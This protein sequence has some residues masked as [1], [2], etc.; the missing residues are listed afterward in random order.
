MAN[1]LYFLLP[2]VL[3]CLQ[4][5][6]AAQTITVLTMNVAGLP[7]IIN[8]NG[9]GDKK[10]N[11]L[12]IGTAFANGNF[13]VIHAQEDFNYHAYIYKTDTHLFR[14]ATS[15]GVPFGSGL[16]TLSNFAFS[17][18]QRT[19]W[20]KCYINEGDCLTPKGF[21]SMTIT[22]DQG[23]QIDFYN[24]HADAGDKDGDGEARVSNLAQVAKAIAD[25]S[26][27]RA[28]IVMGDTNC[29]YTRAMDKLSDFITASGVADPWVTLHRGGVAPAQGADPLL[30]ADPIPADNSCETVDKI[31]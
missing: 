10:Q 17:N 14:T 9:E 8:G 15:G 6:N 29:R 30:C 28:V 12:D 16:N 11:S 1:F 21:T 22:F 2:I 26:A 20:D 24:L 27:G 3:T 4:A 19:K 31:L 25:N 18:L 13:D 23:K 5:V 7:A